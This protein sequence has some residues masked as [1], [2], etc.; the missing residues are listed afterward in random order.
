MKRTKYIF[1]ENYDQNLSGGWSGIRADKYIC[2][3]YLPKLCIY[4]V[5]HHLNSFFFKSIFYLFIITILQNS[6]FAGFASFFID[7]FLT[8]FC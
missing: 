1:S 5:L 4:Q 6:V 3:L 8:E 2:S 7:F